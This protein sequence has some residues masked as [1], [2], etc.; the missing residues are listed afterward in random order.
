[1][2]GLVTGIIRTPR[3]A[4]IAC[5]QETASVVAREPRFQSNLTAVRSCDSHGN[6]AHVCSNLL[7]GRATALCVVWQRQI[8]PASDIIREIHFNTRQVHL[9]RETCAM[10]LESSLVSQD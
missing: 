4:T 3:K 2:D 8:C 10:R 1:M 7:R 5:A 9:V 6:T